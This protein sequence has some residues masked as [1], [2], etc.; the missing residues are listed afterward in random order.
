VLGGN[1]ADGSLPASVPAPIADIL[2]L[3]ARYDGGRPGRIVDAFALEK[4]FGK[5][6]KAVYGPRKYHPFQMPRRSR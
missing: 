6:A 3:H 5:V 2:R 1:P 4:E